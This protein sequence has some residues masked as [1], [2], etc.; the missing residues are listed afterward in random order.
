MAPRFS[1]SGHSV[2]CLRHSSP[3]H[4]LVTSVDTV[5]GLRASALRALLLL[6]SLLRLPFRLR[7]PR[8]FARRVPVPVPLPVPVLVAFLFVFVRVRAR[9]WFRPCKYAGAAAC[10][11]L[12]P[13]VDPPLLAP[14]FC[15]PRLLCD[16]SGAILLLYSTRTHSV[17]SLLYSVS[18]LVLWLCSRSHCATHLS[19]PVSVCELVRVC[20]RSESRT[21]RC[22]RRGLSCTSPLRSAPSIALT[23][24]SFVLLALLS[25]SLYACVSCT[26][27]FTLPPACDLVA[28]VLSPCALPPFLILISNHYSQL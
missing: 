28:F 24:V 14:R 1:R 5:A 22:S 19:A 20:G 25:V 2:L 4:P 11:L 26:S 23:R 17:T 10:P 13:P 9:I 15:A 18:Y 3:L 16:T 12:S 6:D 21:I 7:L 8:S 27:L